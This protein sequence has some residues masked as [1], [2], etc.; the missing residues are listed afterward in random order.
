MHGGDTMKFNTH[1][2]T[3]I[4]L[5]LTNIQEVDDAGIFLF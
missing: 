3:S 4:T 2:R 1:D 5:P